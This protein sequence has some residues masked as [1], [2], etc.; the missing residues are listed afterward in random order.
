MLKLKIKDLNLSINYKVGLRDLEVPE[1]VAKQLEEI[2]H[3]G[4]KMDVP[5]ADLGE[6]NEAFEW[7]VENIKEKD[8][9]GYSFH[10][11]DISVETY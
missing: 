10:V 2:C 4:I 6:Y 7:I 11:Y 3:K 1:E 5:K 8:L 9:F